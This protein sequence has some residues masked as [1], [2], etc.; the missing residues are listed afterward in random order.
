MTE[1]FV[2]PRVTRSV[3]NDCSKRKFS[4]SI[5]ILDISRILAEI[6]SAAAAGF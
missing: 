5:K 4:R 1:V 3:Y 2:S 6:I